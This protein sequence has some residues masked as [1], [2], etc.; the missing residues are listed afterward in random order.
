MKINPSPQGAVTWKAPAQPQSPPAQADSPHTASAQNDAVIIS[1][2]GR[3]LA[4]GQQSAADSRALYENVYGAAGLGQ[5]VTGR[6]HEVGQGRSL[7]PKLLSTTRPMRPSVFGPPWHFL[8]AASAT[9]AK[10]K[11]RLPGWTV[12]ASPT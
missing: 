5:R 3:A 9:I 6:F 8:R 4:V 7:K 11:I 10:C 2:Q 12:L 1:E